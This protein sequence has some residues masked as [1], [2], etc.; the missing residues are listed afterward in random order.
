MMPEKQSTDRNLAGSVHIYAAFIQGDAVFA[1]DIES[2]QKAWE[3]IDSFGE[4]GRE[5]LTK[6][7]RSMK[8]ISDDGF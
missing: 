8:G 5:A 1:P 3:V 6:A 4:A 2:V 7:V